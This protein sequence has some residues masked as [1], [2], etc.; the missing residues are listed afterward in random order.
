MTGRSKAGCRF[1]Q[2]LPHR[3]GADRID[4]AQD[5]HLV[6]QESQSPM[7]P[8][9]GWVSARQF[10]QLLFDV[11][12]D[13]YLI[14]PCRAWSGVKR[15][16]D[17]LGN[18][19]FPDAGDG[20]QARSQGRDDFLVSVPLT[21]HGIGQE[22]DAGVSEPTARCLP[23]RDQVFQPCMFLRIQSD[24]VL[25]HLSAPSLEGSGI[26]RILKR[27]ENVSPVNLRLTAH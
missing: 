17:A 14:R 9:T 1:F 3:L 15:R 26:N 19:P 5:D 11:S 16:L 25:F 23:G 13:L 20:P 4:Q 24:S 22:Q 21:M 7:A 12:F 2:R 10:N 8:P 18:E 27:Q 6:G